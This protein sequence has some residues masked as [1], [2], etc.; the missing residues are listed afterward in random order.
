MTLTAGLEVHQQLD[1]GKLFC[2]CPAADGS[3]DPGFSRQLH[4]TASEMGQVD[5]AAAAENVRDFGYHQGNGN[6]LVE[7]DEEPPRGPNPEAVEVALQVAGLLGA[8]PLEEV[9]FMRKVVV[10]GSNTTGFQRTALVATGGRLDYDGGS[11]D[12]EQLCLEE[13]SCR[14]GDGNDEFLLDRLGVPLLEIS[15]APQLH[16]PEAVQAAARALGQLLRACRVRRGLGTIRQD[17]NVSIPQGVRVELKG[18]QD[19]GTMPQVVEREM[20]RQAT[21]AA[22]EACEPG[23]A[24]EITAL[25]QKPREAWGCRLPGWAGLLGSPESPAGHPRLGR[26]LAD[27]A[28]R[29]GVAGLLHSDE[30]PAQ[31]VSADEAAA[32]AAELGCGEADAFIL[33]FEKKRVATAALE[34][35]C[36]R[37]RQGGVPHEV[38]RVLAEGDSRYLR[39]MP[40]AARMYPETD[41]PPLPLAGNAVELPP[42]LAERTAALP[43]GAQQAE[44]LVRAS[45][46]AR[47]HSLVAAGG[48]PKAVARL[49]LHQL[50]ELRKAG[51]PAPSGAALGELLAAVA[52]G[53]LVKEGVDDALAALA[54]GETL[55]EQAVSGAGELDAFIEQ[56][57]TERKDF[58]QQRGMEAVGPLMGAVMGEF[59]GRVDGALVNERLRVKLEEFLG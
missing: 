4:A 28:R 30:L 19:L 2:S 37:A 47:F 9:H 36:D 59:R 26:E 35:A 16:T 21:L 22:I 24:T 6:C 50:P 58:V 18:F 5:A 17:L 40:G 49:L 42:T 46:D 44:Q 56:L 51:L 8:Q 43:L 3:P 10:D 15:T 7:A 14:R 41:I 52:D 45:L 57:L 29:A 39:P 48:P 13:D 20:E 23:P 1:C 54:R 32:V 31:G 34:R 27:H 53:K 12:I 11:V 33:V 25:L 38:R 55:P